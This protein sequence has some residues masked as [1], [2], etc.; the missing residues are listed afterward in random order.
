MELASVNADAN[1]YKWMQLSI[2]VLTEFKMYEGKRSEYFT[3]ISLISQNKHQ[4]SYRT[5]HYSHIYLP[6]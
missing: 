6:F 1:R 3:L 4:L 5:I 2:C